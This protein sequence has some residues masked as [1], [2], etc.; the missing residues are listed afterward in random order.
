MWRPSSRP[1]RVCRGR[2]SAAA[3][4]ELLESRRVRVRGLGIRYWA[5]AGPAENGPADP[6]VVLLHGFL[7]SGIQWRGTMERLGSELRLLAP[8]L[9]GHG[10]SD[11]PARP[12]ALGDYADTLEGWAEALGLGPSIVIGHSF[13]GMVAVDWTGRY[14]D[15]AAG[16][17]LVAPA[18]VPHRW[19][20]PPLGPLAVPGLRRVLG[21]LWI[22]FLSS[23][24][25]GWR[26][27]GHIVADP[28]AVDP[29]VVRDFQWS[30]RR[31][32]EAFRRLDFYEF[33]ELPERLQEIAAPVRILW[34]SLDRV[35]DPSDAYVFLRHLPRAEL[36]LL[37]GCGHAPMVEKPVLFDHWL[38]ETVRRSGRQGDHLGIS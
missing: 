33:P 34:G 12:Q 9:P 26:F 4:S 20:R 22:W 8:D 16:V 3:G 7:S 10:L 1:W 35:L 31:A 13:G 29:Q 38:M 27:F 37:D 17:G 2:V 30:F 32:R 6:P 11:L 25:V 36:T 19:A 23:R 15:R 24:P 21:P 18:G 14:P 5:T 28:K